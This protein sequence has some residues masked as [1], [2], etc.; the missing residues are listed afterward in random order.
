MKYCTESLPRSGVAIPAPKELF[1]RWVLQ[2]QVQTAMKTCAVPITEGV[3]GV[4]D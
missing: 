2:T 3:I 4:G 1:G